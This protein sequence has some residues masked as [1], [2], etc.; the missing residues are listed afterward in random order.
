MAML[1]LIEDIRSRAKI[2]T[3][4]AKHATDWI[5]EVEDAVGPVGGRVRLPECKAPNGGTLVVGWEKNRFV[6]IAEPV[7]MVPIAQ[8]SRQARIWFAESKMHDVLLALRDQLSI[9]DAAATNE[10]SSKKTERGN[11]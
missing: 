1:D 2:L 10:V 5:K 9:P 3:E 7:G 11:V 8:T 6:A 4:R